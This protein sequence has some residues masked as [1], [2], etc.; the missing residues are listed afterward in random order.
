M[1]PRD[2]EIITQWGERLQSPLTIKLYETSDPRTRQLEEFCEDLKR[3]AVQIKIVREEPAADPLPSIEVGSKVAYRAVPE[4]PEL[5]PFLDLLGAKKIPETLPAGS[6]TPPIEELKLPAHF[7][8]FIAS[9]CPF[10]PQAVARMGT[11]TRNEN[12]MKLTIVDSVLFHDLSVREKIRSV[13]TLVMDGE[14]R[15]SSIPPWAELHDV[16]ANRDPARLGTSALEDFLTDGQ[17]P[18]LAE[19]MI[20]K[21]KIF[22]AYLELLTHSRWPTRLGAMVAFEYLAAGNP[23]LA[24]QVIDPLCRD[25]D[26]L[27][28][29]IQGDI[30]QVLGTTGDVRVKSFLQAVASGDY[31]AE[32][33]AAADETLVEMHSAGR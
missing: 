12:M 2:E 28:G 24:A 3:L 18:K 26:G 31:E 11:Y 30:L 5:K 25:F 19:L 16:M 23:V 20:K 6:P 17:A 13:P 4:G 7:E 1:I 27:A 32:V 15:W 14:F 22:P 9:Q 8:L 10:C 29:T 21:D 33:R